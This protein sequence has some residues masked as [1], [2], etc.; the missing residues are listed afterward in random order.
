M[1]TSAGT[2]AAGPILAID[3]GK[4]KCVACTDRGAAE[5]TFQTI[6]TAQQRRGLLRLCGWES[7]LAPPSG[8]GPGPACLCDGRL[9][10]VGDIFGFPAQHPGETSEQNGRLALVFLAAEVHLHPGH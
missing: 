10:L 7:R 5:P 9:L 6:D 3:L 1:T 4:Y 8:A 2:A